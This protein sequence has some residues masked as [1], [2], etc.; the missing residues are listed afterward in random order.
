[1]AGISARLED[2]AE[3]LWLNHAVV[4]RDGHKLPKAL[5]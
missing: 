1:V 2:R 5:A 3:R 4:D